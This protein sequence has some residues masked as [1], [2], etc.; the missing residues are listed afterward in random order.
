MA[1]NVP[2]RKFDTH[3]KAV[4]ASWEQGMANV[5]TKRPGQPIVR[6]KCAVLIIFHGYVEENQPEL[7]YTLGKLII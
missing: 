2:L 1:V 4:I 3:G 7:W 5:D 6:G